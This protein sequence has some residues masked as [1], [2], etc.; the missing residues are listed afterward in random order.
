M[1]R[2][3]RDHETRTLQEKHMR[4]HGNFRAYVLIVLGA[5]LLLSK[6]GWIPNLAPLLSEW[7]PALLVLAGITMLL[8]ASLRDRT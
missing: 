4:S 5:F 2:M 1:N 6:Q 7:W 8:R 3:P